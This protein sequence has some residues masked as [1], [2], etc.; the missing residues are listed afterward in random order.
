[1][2]AAVV[3]NFALTE[4]DV[5]TV[6]I[7]CQRLE[8]NPAAL[9]LAVNKLK[10]LSPRQILDR[11]NQPLEF[12]KGAAEHMHERHQSLQTMIGVTVAP[13]SDTAK[14][15]LG[16]LALL[17]G[18]AGMDDIEAMFPRHASLRAFEDLIDAG[19]LDPCGAGFDVKRFTMA[20]STRAFARLSL[21]AKEREAVEE[22]R[23]AYFERVALQSASG[24]AGKDQMAWT[25]RMEEQCPDISSTVRVLTKR[26]EAERA[27]IM[28]VSGLTF[29]FE[30][31]FPSEALALAEAVLRR[32]PNFPSR[33]RLENFAAIMAHRLGDVNTAEAYAKRGLERAIASRNLQFQFFLYGTLG[34]IY[35]T[36]NRFEEGERYQ[37]KAIEIARKCGENQRAHTAI[38][39]L[40]AN[41]FAKE[42]CSGTVRDYSELVREALSLESE[43]TSSSW[44]SRLR[45]N[46][47]NA[48]L[49]LGNPVR[50][51]AFCREA[52][53]L[54]RE[55]GHL[56][57][58]AGTVRTLAHALIRQ[59][60]FAEAASLFGA[61]QAL[62]ESDEGRL[63]DYERVLTEEGIRTIVEAIG[64]SE[65]GSYFDAGR[66]LD[67]EEVFEYA[68][69]CA[70]P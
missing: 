1:M 56:V 26:G 33:A 38:T 55:S 30:R 48:E 25:R 19:L 17:D 66:L 31:N 52:L 27:T 47:A 64:Q 34:N 16:C 3:P 40:L 44:K 4:R 43:E 39:N 23:L 70:R 36:I 41:L 9:T 62:V 49:V 42:N 21:D 63:T 37:R 7:I 24:L 46:I 32:K 65:F 53:E 11:L 50:C 57:S 14:S 18:A 69:S 22:R 68:I 67:A 15:L 54:L 60:R 8:G 5:E 58:A 12:L 13:L 51:K 59:S 20:P 2:T 28:L 35:Q 29:W 6:A 61:A 10:A 45:Q